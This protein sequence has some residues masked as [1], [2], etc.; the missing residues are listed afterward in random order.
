MKKKKK[1]KILF[2][3]QNAIIISQFSII[4]TFNYPVSLFSNTLDDM[5]FIGI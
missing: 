4:D 5:K 1:K 3:M 2:V